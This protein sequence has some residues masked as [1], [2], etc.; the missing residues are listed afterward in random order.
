[1]IRTG[2]GQP[3]R[4][5]Q[6]GV[7]L[8]LILGA[9]PISARAEYS[10]YED[11]A[12][13]ASFSLDLIGA[14]FGGS[15]AWFGESESF[16]GVNTNNWLEIGV[17]PGL[18]LEWALGTGTAYGEV[19]GVYTRTFGDDASGLTFGE[20]NPGELTL[21]QAH[22]GWRTDDLFPGLSND[23]LSISLG[24]QDYS[25]GTGM[26][27]DDGAADGGNRGGWYLSIRKAFPKSLITRLKSDELLV[28]AF[29]LENDP[30]SGGTN[31]D[32]SGFN[33]EYYFGDHG[34]VGG[35]YIFVDSNQPGADELDVY[36]VRGEWKLLEGFS[37]SGEYVRE[38]SSQI[39]ADGWY[40]QGSY[41]IPNL[42]WAPVVS[43]RYARFDGDDPD[44]S[45]DEQFREI[46]YGYTD[47]GYWYQGEITGNYPLGNGNLKSH[48][49]RAQ[50]TPR[51]GLSAGLTYYNFSLDH[52]GGLDSGII[53]NDWGDE[54]N[55]IVDWE[56]NEHLFV[57]AVL[58]LLMPGDAAQQWVGGSDNWGYAMLYVSYSL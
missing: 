21:E 24:R 14:G 23:T 20:D 34:T 8:A 32:A 47:Y 50:T 52:P 15:D 56:A 42:N 13:R 4:K 39:E 30:R 55:L 1:M 54:I 37:L 49:L 31:G 29:Y 36:S 17:E 57:T 40:A 16:L 58:G 48:M 7:A 53:S 19:S 5:R 26:I 9:I 43:Y 10:L 33:A 44:T 27:I 25:I 18:A 51:E 38:S 12:T 22:V 45:T 11:G 28:E 41:Q 2:A 3:D 46:A 35:S 6:F